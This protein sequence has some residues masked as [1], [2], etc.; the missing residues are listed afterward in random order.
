MKTGKARPRLA[1]T[2][3]HRKAGKLL[4]ATASTSNSR[5]FSSGSCGDALGVLGKVAHTRRANFST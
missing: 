4:H 2:A 5:A 1:E 3:R